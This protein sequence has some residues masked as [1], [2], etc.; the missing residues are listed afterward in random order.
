MVPISVKGILRGVRGILF[1][2]NPRGE[3][4]LP[5][6][7]PD[8][9]E[10]LEGALR[11]EIVEECGIKIH[12]TS[13]M[14][15]SSFQ[16]VPGQRVLIAVFDCGFTAEN[17]VVSNEHFGYEWVDPER[18]RPA[19]MPHFYWEIIYRLRNVATVAEVVPP[20][21]RR[22]NHSMPYPL[23]IGFLDQDRLG[24]TSRIYDASSEKF[25]GSFLPRKGNILDVGCGHGQMTRWMARES[26]EAAV[27]GI[28]FSRQQIDVARVDA[29][30]EEIS[31][32]MFSTG[33]IFEL[34]ESAMSNS[35][36]DLINCRFVLLHIQDRF[37]ALTNLLERLNPGGILV[38]EEPS[39][40]SLYSVPPVKAFEEANALIRR[41]G[42]LNGI[43]YDCIEEVWDCV[44]RLN[45]RVFAANFSQPTIWTPELKRIVG[46]SFR[47]F[48][49][50]LIACGL[51]TPTDAERISG[52][53]DHE[54]MQGHV[55][56]TGL[57]TLQLALGRANEESGS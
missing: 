55:I 6:G 56:S 27:L 1:L 8:E 20:D 50:R 22:S 49:D 28:D 46:L 43:N 3:L 52:D 54:F 37:H 19:V 30:R 11:R 36:F 35:G 21:V 42:L 10:D 41:F 7:R 16:V 34:P 33:D 5:G 40:A 44:H 25:L 18:E 26:P 47:Q 9:G 29:Q 31:N 14:G 23:Q 2:K 53:L 15:S 24:I 13:Y 51:V 38:T 4:E 48:Q 39:L 17:P 32:V 12:A 57:R 45:A